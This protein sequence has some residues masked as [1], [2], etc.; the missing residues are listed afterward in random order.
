MEVLIR[1]AVFFHSH[2]YDMPL[3]AFGSYVYDTAHQA[4]LMESRRTRAAE[5]NVFYMAYSPMVPNFYFVEVSCFTSPYHP[6]SF[7]DVSKE[8]KLVQA[9]RQIN[10]SPSPA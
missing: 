3:L 4:A 8:W 1:L 6:L 9:L 10:W 5:L 7:K 2:Y